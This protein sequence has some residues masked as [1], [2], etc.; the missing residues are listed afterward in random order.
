[1][2]NYNREKKYAIYFYT[3]DLFAQLFKYKSSLS[4]IIENYPL[5]YPIRFQLPARRYDLKVHGFLL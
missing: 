3:R 5:F 1:M 4:Y 2:F